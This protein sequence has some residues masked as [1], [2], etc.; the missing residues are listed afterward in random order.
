MSS[1]RTTSAGVDDNDEAIIWLASGLM[2]E[3]NDEWSMARGYK[4]FQTKVRITEKANIILA[5]VAA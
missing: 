5:T 2:L 4:S 1:S 3:T